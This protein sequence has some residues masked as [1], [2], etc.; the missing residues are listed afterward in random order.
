LHEPASKFDAK[1]R[2]S[3]SYNF[4]YKFLERTM[5]GVLVAINQSI[6][7]CVYFRLKTHKTETIGDRLTYTMPTRYNIVLN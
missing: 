6:K 2:A 7:Q 4:L 3:F 5:S 1:T